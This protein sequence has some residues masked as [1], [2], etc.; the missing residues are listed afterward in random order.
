[1]KEKHRKRLENQ[2][3]SLGVDLEC[4]APGVEMYDATIASRDS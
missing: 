3:E 1:M 4:H 2:G